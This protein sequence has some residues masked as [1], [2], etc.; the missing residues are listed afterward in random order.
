[1]KNIKLLFL[2]IL[3]VF[4]TAC[5]VE[6]NLTVENNEVFEEIIILEDNEVMKSKYLSSNIN[7]I[8]DELET[9]FAHQFTPLYE[10]E[11]VIGEE[12]SGFII[13]RRFNSYE[14]ILVNSPFLDNSC[15]QTRNFT[16]AR[17]KITINM[18]N[19]TKC[20]IFI[21][22]GM[23]TVN[24]ISDVPLQEGNFDY[25]T[26]GKY[27][28]RL[29]KSPEENHIFIIFDNGLIPAGPLIKNQFIQSI[30]VFAFGLI[31]ISTLVGYLIYR[32]YKKV[33]EL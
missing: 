1:M 23:Y 21:P 6:Y 9:D 11:K 27:T 24:V 3:V 4:L 31:S 5:D 29:S 13:S 10:F 7:F 19:Q 33:N 14:H 26:E 8:L 15:F 18:N 25:S 20:D 17:N 12:R 32:R 28:W 2:L 30:L 22:E 16:N